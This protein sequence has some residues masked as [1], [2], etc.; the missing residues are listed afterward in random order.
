MMSGDEIY[1]DEVTSGLEEEDQCPGWCPA[2]AGGDHDHRDPFRT[3]MMPGQEPYTAEEVVHLSQ[4]VADA[5]EDDPGE[6]G[7][8]EYLRQRR[9][10]RDERSRAILAGEV[11][12]WGSKPDIEA[13]E[14]ALERADLEEDE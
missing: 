13:V 2:R 4:F 9:A 10:A 14:D 3:K 11:P 8:A 12:A 1:P 5:A 7:E 6:A